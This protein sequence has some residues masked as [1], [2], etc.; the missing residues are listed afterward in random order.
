MVRIV[1]EKVRLV[2]ESACNYDVPKLVNGPD[3]A[4]TAICAVWPE[5]RQE[6]QEVLSL[7]CLNTKGKIVSMLELTRGGLSSAQIH[8]REIY[9]SA[10]LANAASIIL[11][12]NHPSGDPAPSPQDIEMTRKIKEAGE[13][14]GIT[15]NDHIIIGDDD[16][17][18][19]KSRL[20][21]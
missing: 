13:L 10:L 14:L 19:L 16:Y 17:C 1:V 18:S 7:I 2:R 6:A 8:P 15:L 20:L 9:K 5:Y 3:D 11:V 4:F 12:H 21:I